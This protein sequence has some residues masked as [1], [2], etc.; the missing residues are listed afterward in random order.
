MFQQGTKSA[1][2]QHVTLCLSVAC[3]AFQSQSDKLTFWLE[4][5]QELLLHRWHEHRYDMWVSTAAV[6]LQTLRSCYADFTHLQC[7]VNDSFLLLE[8]NTRPVTVGE[9]ASTLMQIDGTYVQHMQRTIM[10]RLHVVIDFI[11]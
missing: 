7:C 10:S 1:S 11:P 9:P 8:Y 5:L 3:V 2:T 6:V 4:N